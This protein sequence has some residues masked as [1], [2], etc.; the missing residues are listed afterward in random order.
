MRTL[1]VP[2][3]THGRVLLKMT[4]GVISKKRLPVSF[5]A[6]VGFHGYAQNAE[7]MMDVLGRLPGASNCSLLSVQALN[8]FYTRG[9]QTIVA[10]WMTR[11]DREQT[12]A[13]NIAYVDQVLRSVENDIG[14]RFSETTPDVVF[15][16]FSQ[17]VAMAY[18]AA[19][20]GSYRA[21][22][23]IAIGGDVPPDV[24]DVPASRWP[25]VM[26]AAGAK[27]A[28]YNAEKV[29]ADEAFL[30]HHGVTHEIHRS[31]AGH[32][33]TDEMLAVAARFIGLA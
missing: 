24:R 31:G 15:V 10:S 8:R 29:S 14:C 19:L 4:P 26:I 20:R 18:R 17:G 13:D 11:Q 3:Q 5:S 32:E 6:I 33:I 12:I 25:R 1:L 28:W 9:D 16:G 23:V 21:A 2:T 7:D 22:A 27:D 30:K